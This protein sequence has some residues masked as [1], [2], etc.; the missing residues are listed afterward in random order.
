VN[1]PKLDLRIF[2]R[3]RFALA[4][5]TEPVIPLYAIPNALLYSGIK[6]RA[7][8][9]VYGKPET[10]LLPYDDYGP[11]HRAADHRQRRRARGGDGFL[12][13]PACRS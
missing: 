10:G 3:V 2:R 13:Q 6:A 7:C 9:A 1:L 5:R 8:C 12:Y 4:S 11:D